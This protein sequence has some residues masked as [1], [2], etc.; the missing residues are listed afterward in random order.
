MVLDRT[1]RQRA[2]NARESP[3][4]GPD[5]AGKKMLGL[6]QRLLLTR[7]LDF[8]NLVVLPHFGAVNR[9]AQG[10]GGVG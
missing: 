4:W 10:P 6:A 5:G 2:S 9:S 8:D 1:T 3:F 7:K